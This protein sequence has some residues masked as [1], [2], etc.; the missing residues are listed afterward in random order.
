[1][2][3]RSRLS[4]ERGFALVIALA[5]TI[6]LGISVTSMIVYTSSNQHTAHLSKGG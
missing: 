3:F 1:M 2:N 4:D 5:T 6:V